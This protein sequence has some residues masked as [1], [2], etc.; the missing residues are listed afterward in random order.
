MQFFDHHWRVNGE[1]RKELIDNSWD[2]EA[3][4]VRVTL[5]TILSEGSPLFSVE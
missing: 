3:T 5:P 4:K 2:A 1:R